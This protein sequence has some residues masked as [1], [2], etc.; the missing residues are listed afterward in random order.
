[1]ECW[2]GLYNYEVEDSFVQSVESYDIW[3]FFLEYLAIESKN[4]QREREYEKELLVEQ[5]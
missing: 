5:N 1:M 2:D 3:G 4:Q